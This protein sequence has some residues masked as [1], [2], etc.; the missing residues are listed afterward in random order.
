MNDTMKRAKM[1][2]LKQLLNFGDDELDT[3]LKPKATVIEI[4]IGK[5]EMKMDEMKSTKEPEPMTEDDDKELEDEEEETP[6]D[7]SMS[8]EDLEK[9]RKKYNIMKG[10]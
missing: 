8:E 10:K 7:S 2:V 1:E 3:K 6:K 5:P 4:G 9:I